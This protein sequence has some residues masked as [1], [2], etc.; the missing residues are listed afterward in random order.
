MNRFVKLQSKF[1]CFNCRKSFERYNE[2]NEATSNCPE[3]NTLTIRYDPRFKVPKRTD[4]KQWKKIES[5]RDNG[6]YFQKI[7]KQ[8]GTSSYQRVLYP[9]DLSEVAEFVKLYKD[10]AIILNKK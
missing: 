4:D 7:Y 6:F 1:V 10:Q 9:K 5:L 8:V 2:S 3:C